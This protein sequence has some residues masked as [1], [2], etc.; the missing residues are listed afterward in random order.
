LESA[1]GPSQPL[2]RLLVLLAFIAIM[3][4][5]LALGLGVATSIKQR[6]SRR[7]LPP[8]PGPGNRDPGGRAPGGGQRGETGHDPVPPG[9]RADE[10][11]TDLR[12]RK[13]RQRGRGIPARAGRPAGGLRPATGTA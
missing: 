8:R 10:I 12:A 4:A 9:H 6:G 11:Q 13:P 5:P 2:A 1:P 7:Q 3:T